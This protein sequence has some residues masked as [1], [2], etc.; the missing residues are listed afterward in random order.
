MGTGA[1]RRRQHFQIGIAHLVALDEDVGA[2]E[3]DLADL[4]LA[5]EQRERIEEKRQAAHARQIGPRAPG[6]VR[7][8][9]AFGNHRRLAAE[10]DGERDAGGQLAAGDLSDLLGQSGLIARQ[11]AGCGPDDADDGS[12]GQ[13]HRRDHRHAPPGNP[14][15]VRFSLKHRPSKS[16]MPRRCGGSEVAARPAS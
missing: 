10:P 15:P 7:E 8:S 14:H 3:Q 6:C 2:F 13:R 4:D 16:Q 1:I 5:Q 9:D 12:D 11:V